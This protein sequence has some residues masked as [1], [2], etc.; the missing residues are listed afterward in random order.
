MLNNLKQK[1]HWFGILLWKIDSKKY[2]S[3]YFVLTIVVFTVPMHYSQ[4]TKWMNKILPT[5][6][7]VVLCVAALK[8]EYLFKMSFLHFHSNIIFDYR[9]KTWFIFWRTR[10]LCTTIPIWFDIKINAINAGMSSRE[11]FIQSFHSCFCAIAINY[12]TITLSGS[13]ISYLR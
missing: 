7:R 8:V 9:I 10:N 3:N 5:P 6:F 2:A 1:I 12:K 11:H 13:N 4:L